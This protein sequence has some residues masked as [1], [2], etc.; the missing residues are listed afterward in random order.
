MDLSVYN[1]A[2]SMQTKAKTAESQKYL[3]SAKMSI[4][5]C[6]AWNSHKNWEGYQTDINYVDF[7]YWQFYA[8]MTAWKEAKSL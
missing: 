3:D 8:L 4:P 2:S 1:V 6:K 7:E 5:Q